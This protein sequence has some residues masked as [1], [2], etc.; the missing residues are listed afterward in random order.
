M[1]RLDFVLATLT[2]AEGS[3]GPIALEAFAIGFEAL[4]VLAVA[5]LPPVR[6]QHRIFH[7]DA[8][9]AALAKL[10]SLVAGLE[11]GALLA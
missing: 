3:A 4:G 7:L 5:V 8:G 1:G 6:H 9:F 10:T 2:A 11:A